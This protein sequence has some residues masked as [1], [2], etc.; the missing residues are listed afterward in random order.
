M[1]VV[2]LFLVFAKISFCSFGGLSMLPL[3]NAE[4]MSR[5]WMTAAELADMIAIAEM[6]PGPMT[7]NCATFVGMRTAGISGALCATLG[8]MMPSLTI[9]MLAGKFLEQFRSSQRLKDALYGIRP[10]SVGMIAAVSVTLAGSTF[11]SAGSPDIPGMLVAALALFLLL[12][13]KLSVPKL[14]LLCAAAG[15]LLGAMGI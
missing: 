5:G 3:I 13:F 4:L 10:A 7:I 6:T 9:C 2:R 14:V 8:V 15:L 12:K 11:L 1:I